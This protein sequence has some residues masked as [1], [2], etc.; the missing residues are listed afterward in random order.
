MGTVDFETFETCLNKTL[1]FLCMAS[2]Y[3]R[4]HSARFSVI[5][6]PP[7]SLGDLLGLTVESLTVV[8]TRTEEFSLVRASYESIN[9]LE[10]QFQLLVSFSVDRINLKFTHETS[11][12]I[13]REPSCIFS[14]YLES[15]LL[16]PA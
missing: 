5:L 4:V 13:C 10:P 9:V 11:N 6:I 14:P 2:S 8:A 7:V 3:W 12:I 16:F 15:S 1:Y